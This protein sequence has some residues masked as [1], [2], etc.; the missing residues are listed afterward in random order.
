M[1]IPEGQLLGT[2]KPAMTLLLGSHASDLN[3][4]AGLVDANQ[5]VASASRSAHASTFH[6]KRGGVSGAHED[7]ADQEDRDQRE[8]PARLLVLARILGFP[9]S[10]HGF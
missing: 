10:N 7:P 4:K 9:A 2:N 1:R 6:K 8:D 5:H 3:A